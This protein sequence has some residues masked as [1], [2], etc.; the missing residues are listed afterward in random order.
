MKFGYQLT[1]Y[2]R[3]N[4]FQ[5][6]GRWEHRQRTRKTS[7]RPKLPRRSKALN[8]AGIWERMSIRDISQADLGGSHR[9]ADRSTFW[10]AAPTVDEVL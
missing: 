10:A 1:G 6:F 9:G 3:E 4:V 2:Q 5:E 8:L 7:Q